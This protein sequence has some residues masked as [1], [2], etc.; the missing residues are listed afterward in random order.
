MDA[1]MSQINDIVQNISESEFFNNKLFKDIASNLA[2]SAKSIAVTFSFV[3]YY[4]EEWTKGAFI[5][6]DSSDGLYCSTNKWSTKDE[7]PTEV[8]LNKK[9][10]YILFFTLGL[11]VVGCCVIFIVTRI[12]NNRRPISINDLFRVLEDNGEYEIATDSEDGY[13][14]DHSVEIDLPNE[15]DS[16]LTPLPRSFSSERLLEEERNRRL[17]VVCKD[18]I[19]S[20]L[21][22]PCKHLCL[23]VSCAKCLAELGPRRRICPL[24]RRSFKSITNVYL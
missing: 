21:I 24:C 12:N 7:K 23:C 22:M 10:I 8:C 17:C 1:I 13:E 6:E 2:T 9:A 3:S 15:S 19:K 16:R 18:K 11:M 4:L 14:T 20:V 5:H